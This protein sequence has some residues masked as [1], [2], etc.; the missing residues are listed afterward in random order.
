[1][2]SASGKKDGIISIETAKTCFLP[3]H[4][5]KALI[6]NSYGEESTVLYG[7]AAYGYRTQFEFFPDRG[8]GIVIFMNSNENW[9]FMNETMWALKR[10]YDI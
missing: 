5:S 10:S 7:G 3:Q 6:G 1:M 4:N 2:L 9:K 8:W